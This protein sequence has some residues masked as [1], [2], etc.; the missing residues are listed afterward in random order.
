M[1]LIRNNVDSLT[2][3]LSEQELLTL[4]ASMREVFAFL[5]KEEFPLRLGIQFCDAV[6]ISHELSLLMQKMGIQD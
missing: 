3:Q 5:S 1:K 4:K 6:K 2:L